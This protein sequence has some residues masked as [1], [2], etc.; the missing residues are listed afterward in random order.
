M[1]FWNLLSLILK[2]I[3]SKEV[4]LQLR[5]RIR[6]RWSRLIKCLEKQGMLW[7]RGNLLPSFISVRKE[8]KQ[9]KYSTKMEKMDFLDSSQPG[10]PQRPSFFSMQ[11]FI[12]IYRPI[13]QKRWILIQN[14]N[15]CRSKKHRLKKKNPISIKK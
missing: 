10:L 6:F 8:I 2:K 7:L 9:T 11:V 1:K 13:E 5:L 3:R 15:F 14:P 12:K 4:K